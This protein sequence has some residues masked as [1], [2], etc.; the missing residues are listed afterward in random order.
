VIPEVAL[1]T[2]TLHAGAATA[3]VIAATASPSASTVTRSVRQP[4]RWLDRYR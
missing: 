1:K 4:R 2:N 3:A